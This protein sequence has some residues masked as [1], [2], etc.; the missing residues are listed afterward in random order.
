MRRWHAVL[1]HI[2]LRTPFRRDVAGAVVIA[3][4][5]LAAFLARPEP[6]SGAVDVERPWLVVGFLLAEASSVALR[7]GVPVFA[8]GVAVGAMA[9]QMLLLPFPVGGGLAVMI[10]AYSVAAYRPRGVAFVAIAVAA[11]LH[12]V[13]TVAATDPFGQVD[14]AGGGGEINLG[15]TLVMSA[16][17]AF[18]I[19]GLIG[20]YVRSRREYIAVVETRAERLER[21]REARAGRAVADERARIARELHDVAAHHLSAI[22]VQAGAAES[23][24]DDDPD[25][26]K[27][28]LQD[29]RTQ[30][31][32][33]L[34]SMRFLVGVL[35]ARDG[36]NGAPQ[37]GL[38]DIEHLVG[39]ACAAGTKVHL[40]GPEEPPT[41]P[42]A[43]DLA[44]YRIVQESLSN[45]RKHAPGAEV[46][47]NIEAEGDRLDLEVVNEPPPAG[48]LPRT[49]AE[50]GLGLIGMRERVEILSGS[51]EAGPLRGGGWR[52]R[53]SLPLVAPQ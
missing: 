29:V 25:R 1:A 40:N 30:G 16:V 38:D 39:Q 42:A 9:L 52:V 3:S 33:T 32:D 13:V 15:V 2:G 50:P 12:L 48:A 8:L 24:V 7:R 4:V 18:L 44:G 36:E 37:P 14:T 53:A 46:S 51:L 22:V 47:V 45:A 6:V 27:A 26:A 28:L 35:R 17:F 41:C 49:F 31:R 43:I 34:G 5:A 23:I 20:A 10:V 21:E 19:P 11:V